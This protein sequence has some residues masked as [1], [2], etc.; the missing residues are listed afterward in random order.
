MQPKAKDELAA[1]KI[2]LLSI[3]SPLSQYSP[4]F[5]ATALSLI[6]LKPPL[7]SLGLRPSTG[8]SGLSLLQLLRN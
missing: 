8:I 2:H 7:S 1:Y 5:V 4:Y 3:E 6:R